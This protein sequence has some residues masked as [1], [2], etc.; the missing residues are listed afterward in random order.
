MASD[1]I[2][3]KFGRLTVV[4]KA[5]SH[6]SPCGTRCAM[7]I[8][9]CECGNMVTVQGRNLRNGNTKSCGCH[10]SETTRTLHMKHGYAKRSKEE[11][12]YHV[13]KS[14]LSRCYYKRNKRYSR[15]GGRGIRVCD[16]WRNS[17]ESFRTWALENGYDENAPFGKCTIDR[18]N[19]DG[20]YE[21]N[22]CRWVDFKTQA[23]NRNPLPSPYK[24]GDIDG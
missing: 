16:E 22:N 2:S 14:M 5:A 10:R 13:W 19:N 9:E 24:A 8:C 20:N 21:P 18:I 15:Y 12:L 4:D 11:R 3:R 6:V 17:Y 23:N 1:L 7:Y